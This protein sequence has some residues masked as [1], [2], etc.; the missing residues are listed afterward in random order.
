MPIKNNQRGLDQPKLVKHKEQIKIDKIYQQTKT[1]L[2]ETP[3]RPQGF[4]LVVE[5]QPVKCELGACRR[6][7]RYRR[8]NPSIY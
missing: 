1:T 3:E 8:Q 4:G 6:I 7:K 5:V 2:K